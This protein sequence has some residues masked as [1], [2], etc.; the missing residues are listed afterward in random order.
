MCV[1]RYTSGT[2]GS[3]PDHNSDRV[4]LCKKANHHIF[5]GE[6]L[7]LQFIKHVYEVQ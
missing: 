1:Y 5:D 7:C 3:V 4:S 2:V 6:S